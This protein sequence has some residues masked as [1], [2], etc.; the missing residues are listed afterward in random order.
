M[1]NARSQRLE[2]AVSV[3]FLWGVDTWVQ[4][5][6]RRVAR[7]PMVRS[8]VIYASATAG[9]KVVAFIKEAV[10]AA[11]FGVSGAMDAYLMGLMLIGVPLGLLLNAIQTA[12]IPL[13]VEVRETQGTHAGAHFIRSTASAVLLVMMMAL[14]L[15]LIMLPWVMDIVGHGFDTAK[16]TAVRDMFLWLI[17]Y[18]FL[19]GLNLLGYGVLQAD[20]RF[21]SSAIL[22]V[23]IPVVTIAIVL[24][25]G[26]GDVHE[27]VLGFVMGS[28]LEWVVIHL[29]L[30]QNGASLMPGRS[31]VTPETRRLAQGSGALIGGTFVLS[32]TPMIEQGLASGLGEGTVAAMGY[33]F[34]LPSMINGI[35][36]TSVGVTVLPYFA[37]MLARRDDAICRRA[38][39]NYALVLLAG[40]AVLA[41]IMVALSEP[42]VALVFQRGA[43]QAEDTRIVADIQRAYLLQIPGALVGMLAVRLLVAQGAYGIVSIISSLSVVVSGVLAWGLSRQMGAMGIALGLSVAA[44]VSAMILVVLALRQF[45][46]AR[47]AKESVL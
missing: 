38:F 7:Q 33:A 41:L 2:P 10:V 20:K 46:N 39:R 37:E 28:F 47:P 26:T 32:I 19:N 14:I 31:P 5:L 29:R 15:W 44:T 16:Q 45:V 4:G 42:L 27:L 1:W 12:F 43:F 22:P 25:V 30:R 24:G 34:K 11:A 17:P 6:V 35:L 8:A 40:G 13:F 3:R 23:C 9:V 21:L 36:V 18:Y